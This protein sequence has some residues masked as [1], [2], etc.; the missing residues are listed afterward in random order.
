MKFFKYDLSKHR[1]EIISHIQLKN[2]VVM[3]KV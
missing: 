3:V 1:I 2:N